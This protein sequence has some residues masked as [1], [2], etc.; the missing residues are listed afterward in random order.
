MSEVKFTPG[1]WRIEQYPS[2]HV[3]S[4]DGEC[5]LAHDYITDADAHLIAAAPELYEAL[6]EL[7]DAIDSAVGL[8]PE[9]LEKARQ[10]L[11][12]ARGEE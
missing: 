10:A 9:R 11:R 7:Y 6:E 1:P 3:R 8:T 5:V 4:C 12:K 2:I